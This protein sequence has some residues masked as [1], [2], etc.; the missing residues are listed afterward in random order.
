MKKLHLLAA[1]PVALLLALPGQAADVN[2]DAGARI[3]SP[4]QVS[5]VTRLY[6]GTI[7]P[8]TTSAD[9][10]AVAADGAR[11]CGAALTCLDNDH[12]AAAFAVTGEADRSYTI[13]LPNTI[14]ISDGA[15]NSMDV[16]SFV[17]SKTSGTLTSGSDNF[18][19][20]GTLTVG[21]NQASG[22]Y[23]GV[24]TVTVEYQ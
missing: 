12:T 18:T 23:S 2:S 15:G 14:S 16:A 8:S 19:V 22:E 3:I 10:V 17:G 7:A 6:F 21:A 20:G 24:F 13:D 4:L 9:T 1:A 5:N 11:T